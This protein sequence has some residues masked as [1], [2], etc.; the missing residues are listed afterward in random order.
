MRLSNWLLIAAG[1]VA[2]CGT[3]SSGATSEYMGS[4]GE[5]DSSDDDS[6]SSGGKNGS[7]KDAGA[8]ASEHK[9]SGKSTSAANVS[10]DS[11]VRIIDGSNNDCDSLPISVTP[12]SP[13]ILIV[14]DRSSSMT[15]G[16]DRWT[17]ALGAIQSLT[18][19]LQDTV[20]FG[21][22]VF[23]AVNKDMAPAGVDWTIFLDPTTYTDPTKLLDPGTYITLSCDPGV[24]DVPPDLNT[25]D[26]IASYLNMAAPDIGATPTAATLQAAL[27]YLD[28]P[29]ADCTPHDKYVVLMTDG[30]PNCGDGSLDTT[31]ADISAVTDAIDKLAAANIKTYVLGFDLEDDQASVDAMNQFA[32][33]GGTDH[34][35]PIGQDQ[36]GILDELTQIVG[37]S[38][39]CDYEISYDVKDPTYLKVVIDDTQYTLGTDWD[40]DAD[41][42]KLSLHTDGKACVT[43]RDAHV[44]KLSITQECEPQT[45]L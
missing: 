41:N 42:K 32:Q 24:I 28:Q 30:Q 36:A 23:P 8:A 16:V 1:G 40:Y 22:M 31:D 13:D 14:Q 9:D 27:T 33:H 38:I 39:S 7:S 44:H 26:K 43:L 4:A 17:P 20:A 37:S 11:G 10:H 18:S 25:S 3:N 45:F 19:Q 21:L 15:L 12:N 2:A 6:S 29:C 34:Y 5:D 35:R